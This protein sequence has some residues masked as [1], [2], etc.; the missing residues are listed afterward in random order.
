MIMLKK[1]LPI[2]EASFFIIVFVH[3]AISAYFFLSINAGIGDESLFISDLIFIKK[4]GWISAIEKGISIPYLVLAYPLSLL[5]K[6]YIALR[7]VNIILVGMLIFYFKK[8]KIG[9]RPY[10]YAYLIFFISTVGYFFIGTNDTL[11]FICCIIF[12]HQV[13]LLQKNKYWKGTLAISTLIIAFFT[14]ELLIVYCP[15]LLLCIYLIYKE[16]GWV[17]VNKKYILIPTIVLI[18]V[19]IPS[20]LTAK[21]LSYDEK[22]PPENVSVNWVQR[23]YLAQ[24][25]VNNGTL[26]N[27]N[28]PSWEE[29][30]AYVVKKGVDS[31]PDTISR[32]LIFDVKLTVSEFFKDLFT[33][34]FYGF[35]QL[36]LILVFPLIYMVQILYNSK[37][38]YRALLIPFANFLMICVFSLIIISFVELR[39]LAPFFVLSIVYFSDLQYEKVFGTKVVFANYGVLLLLS[40]YGICSL[41][42]K[43]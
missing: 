4:E 26:K 17:A 22:L 27:Y 7:L 40:L 16:K 5:V 2:L 39:W 31:L 28:H 38:N 42:S 35:R 30:Q 14:R 43:Y 29:T 21:K 13:Y 15:V 25:M 3:F 1:L 20:I 8:Q 6:N 41:L 32:A 11:F 33:T 36:G 9:V 18:L 34:F 23:Q 10:F 24:L 37:N 19:N 12:I